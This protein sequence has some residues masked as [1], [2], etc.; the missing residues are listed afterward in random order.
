M[1]SFSNCLLVTATV[2]LER[3]YSIKYGTPFTKPRMTSNSVDM[4]VLTS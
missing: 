1:C 4:F 3:N 2:K